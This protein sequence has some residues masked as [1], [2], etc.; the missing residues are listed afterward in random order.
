VNFTTYYNEVVV[1][2]S[3]RFYQKI[4]F[5]PDFVLLRLLNYIHLFSVISCLDV[6]PLSLSHSLTHSLSVMI[7]ITETILWRNSGKRKR[8]WVSRQGRNSTL[9]VSIV[10]YTVHGLQRKNNKTACN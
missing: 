8:K 7:Y 5:F 2:L 10:K 9:F 6:K 4:I 3:K 1:H